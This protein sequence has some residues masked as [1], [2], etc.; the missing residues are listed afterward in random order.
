[1]SRH[2]PEGDKLGKIARK[3]SAGTAENNYENLEC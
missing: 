2:M 3:H 1:M